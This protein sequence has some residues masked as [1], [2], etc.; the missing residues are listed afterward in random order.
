ML[1]PVEHH[2]ELKLPHRTHNGRG[3]ER[4]GARGVEHLR[5]ALLRELPQPRVELF[6]LERIGSNDPRKMLRRETRDP[7]EFQL[8]VRRKRIA[9]A[10]RAAIHH[11]DHVT[12]PGLLDH[13]PLTRQ[14]LLRARES[15]R[16]A[17]PHVRDRQSRLEPPRADAHEGNPVA[18]LGV[19]VRLDLEH[20]AREVGVRRVDQAVRRLA[21][22]GSRRELHE[23]PQERLD[24]EVGERAREEYRR[25]RTG[26]HRRFAE[27]VPGL[28]E[29]RDV[30]HELR[31]CLA[32]EHVAQTRII[33]RPDLDVRRTRAVIRAA[34][35]AID[36][37]ATSI[38]DTDE[39]AAG[40]D[41][42]RDRIAINAEIGLDVAEKLERI[43]ADAV[44]L[45]DDREDRHATPLAHREQLPRPL[46]DALAVV[47][48]HH[49]A[50]GGDQDAIRVLREVL[51]S[52]RVEQ[53]DLVA[54]VLELHHA[55]RH[56]DAA[57]LLHL[58][59]V[60]RGVPLLAPRLHRPGKVDRATVQQQLLGEGRLSGVRM[61]DDGERAARANRVVQNGVDGHA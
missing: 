55:R 40:V 41:R 8:A 35:E 26:K 36:Q 15:Q 52:R 38:K 48:E 4:V 22:G 27:R 18:M 42:P 56:R 44:A 19:H 60:G 34:L 5:R 14:E 3:A 21:R 29:Q 20:E 28:V 51:V 47:Q 23:F 49:R 13:R 43:L 33:Q 50:V 12:R 25:Q 32:P 6:A 37:L 9:D 16:L 24:A 30:V 53:V 58:H 39:G 17:G 31:V 59:P 1:Q 7:G 45:V 54:L 11:A 10:Q 57:L 61:A 2:V 46:L